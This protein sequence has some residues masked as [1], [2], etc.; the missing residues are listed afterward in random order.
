[1]LWIDKYRPKSLKELSYNVETTQLLQRLVES[2]DFPHLLLYGPTGSGKK[3]RLGAFLY[4]VYGPGVRKLKVDNRNLKVS[5]TS[6]ASVDINVVT[7]SY[8]LEVAPSE[9]AN[10]DRVVIQQ[11]I[12]EIAQSP[13]LQ[14]T[15][16]FKMVVIMNVDQLTREAQAALRR[17]MEK[18]MKSCRLV[19]V[20]NSLSRVLPPVRSRCL[21]LRIG[22]PSNVEIV[23]ILHQI[24]DAEKLQIPDTFATR[25]AQASGRDLR[26][27]ILMLETARVQRY[28]FTDSQLVPK[29]PWE[30]YIQD[31]SGQILI[32]QSPKKLLATRQQ[33][34][35]LLTNC[36]PADIILKLLNAL[37]AP[38]EASAKQAPSHLQRLCPS[39]VATA[40][41]FDHSLRQG[42]KD[43]LH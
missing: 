5:P 20:C 26:K 40:S 15:P 3:T 11:L 10:K 38:K 32:E 13:P 7:S 43:I 33:L 30:V 31:I 24:A 4:E 22:A 39:I 41:Q 9:V 16:S 25:I 17:T 35:D 28:P 18:Y 21:C 36:I 14:T 19:L 6:S 42:T 1:M 2:Q 37:S 29:A 12:K 8:H 23:S 27:A 34:Y